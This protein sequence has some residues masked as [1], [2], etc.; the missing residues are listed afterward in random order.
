M[1]LMLLSVQRSDAA[2]SA[3][4]RTAEV[5]LLQECSKFTY[6]SFAALPNRGLSD[7]SKNIEDC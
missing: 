1:P 5:F 7:F 3:K 4:E 6:R 2:G